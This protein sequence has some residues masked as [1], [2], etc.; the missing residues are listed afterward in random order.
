MRMSS[1]RALSCIFSSGTGRGRSGTDICQGKAQ[2]VA[3]CGEDEPIA[4]RLSR[5]ARQACGGRT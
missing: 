2:A 3:Q 4:R 5:L 1:R